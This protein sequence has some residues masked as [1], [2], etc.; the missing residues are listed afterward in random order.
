MQQKCVAYSSIILSLHLGIFY[1]LML[2][3]G[4]IYDL[5]E[6]SAWQAIMIKNAIKPCNVSIVRYPFKNFI[7]L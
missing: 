7:C 2:H 1:C 5:I 6:M 4:R 3:I